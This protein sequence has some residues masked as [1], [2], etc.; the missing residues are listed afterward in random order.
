MATV[1]VGDGPE[2]YFSHEDGSSSWTLSP[3][4]VDDWLASLEASA[5]ALENKGGTGGEETAKMGL[6]ARNMLSMSMKSEMKKK[7]EANLKG[8]WAVRVHPDTG[9]V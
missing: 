1:L 9:Q 3:S 5:A 8:E 6:S 7:S 4:K 2:R